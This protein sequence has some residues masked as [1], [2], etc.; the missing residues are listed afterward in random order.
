M[1]M[2]KCNS[3]IEDLLF[4]SFTCFRASNCILWV[5]DGDQRIK[6]LLDSD[7]HFYILGFC[8][9]KRCLK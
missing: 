7:F 4:S 9:L 6:T 5:I 2:G 8:V 1:F 3:S